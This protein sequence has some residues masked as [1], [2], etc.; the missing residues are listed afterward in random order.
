MASFDLDYFLKALSSK[1]PHWRLELQH[2][3]LTQ[4]SLQ[5]GPHGKQLPTVAKRHPAL[6]KQ[7][8]N[9]CPASSRKSVN[10]KE[11]P[12]PNMETTTTA[13]SLILTLSDP[14]QS[15]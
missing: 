13:D 8:N 14:E 1:L 15:I 5:Q 11:D 10:F 4:F 9:L 12:D 3:S 7:D 6:A 2:L